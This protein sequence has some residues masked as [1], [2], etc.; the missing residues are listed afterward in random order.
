MLPP[1]PNLLLFFATLLPHSHWICLLYPCRCHFL[2]FPAAVVTP[3]QCWQSG[4][5]SA[6][7]VWKWW[8][9]WRQH[10]QRKG[11]G[12]SPVAALEA[13]VVASSGVAAAATAER[14]RQRQH[15]NG[16]GRAAAG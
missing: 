4:R 11:N 13:V 2:T 10:Q 8:A 12:G 16:G 1:S 7:V 3:R 6:A 9:V 14:Q 15:G 5:G